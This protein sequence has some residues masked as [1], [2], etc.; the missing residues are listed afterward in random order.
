[1]AAKTLV[2]ALA[3]AVALASIAQPVDVDSILPGSVVMQG[4]NILDGRYGGLSTRESVAG[5]ASACQTSCQKSPTCEYFA[6]R[7]GNSSC[8]L[9]GADALFQAG[10]GF[11]S[12]PKVCPEGPMG[13]RELPSDGFP[14]ATASASELAWPSHRVPS[15]LECWPQNSTSGHY[16][17]CPTVTVLED[18]HGGWPAKCSGLTKVAVPWMETCETYC[19]KS[20]K[21]S[22]WKETSDTAP[23]PECYIGHLSSGLNCYLGDASKQSSRPLSG[24]QRL[25]HGKVRVLKSLVGAEIVGL[26]E[27]LSSG[28]FKNKTD[29]IQACRNICYSNVGCQFWQY[30]SKTSGCYVEDPSHGLVV[31]PL[32]T[33]ISEFGRHTSYSTNTTFAKSVIAGEYIQHVCPGLGVIGAFVLPEAAGT[34]TGTSTLYAQVATTPGPAVVAPAHATKASAGEDKGFLSQHMF[35]VIGA[36]AATA[37]LVGLSVLVGHKIYHHDSTQAE[38]KLDKD[39][40][41]SLRSRGASLAQTPSAAASEKVD[42]ERGLPPRLRSGSLGSPT[43]PPRVDDDA[44]SQAV[45]FSVVSGRPEMEPL[46]SPSP[47]EALFASIDTNNDG[48]VSRQEWEQAMKRAAPPAALAPRRLNLPPT[49][50]LP[51]PP[52]G[53]LYTSMAPVPQATT[54]AAAMA[55]AAVASTGAS[56][57]LVPPAFV[58]GTPAQRLATPLPIRSMQLPPSLGDAAS[59]VASSVASPSRLSPSRLAPPSAP[60]SAQAPVGGS[61]SVPLAASPM[62]SIA[63]MVPLGSMKYTGQG[64]P[65][66]APMPT[67][68]HPL[69]VFPPSSGSVWGA[70]VSA[71]PATSVVSMPQAQLFRPHDLGVPVASSPI[72]SVFD[73]V[74]PPRGGQASMF[75]SMGGRLS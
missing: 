23:E 19:Q 45:S 55:A 8:Y 16:L 70:A 46:L 36:C 29:A 3:L 60:A 72:T 63:S 43:P 64:M 50:T 11:I 7:S 66:F 1:M 68:P 75:Q 27:A 42:T 56:Q 24:A 38:K 65:S 20:L 9:S 69:A 30:S 18:L 58:R 52:L 15:K 33:E 28:S 73:M 39:R 61:A 62:S 22:V 10:E 67:P 25:M 41:Q 13:C 35:L 54:A 21:C 74:G 57:G 37:L 6:F 26:V 17:S 59:P 31:Y 14:G 12:G 32:T 5:N 49:T 71:T 48:L 40:R 2:M 34:T 44:A 47:S 4:C 53:M 51:A